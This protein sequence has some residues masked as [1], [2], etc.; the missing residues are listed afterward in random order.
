VSS[1]RKD[2]TQLVREARGAGWN[3]NVTPGGH[4]RFRAPEGG[5]PI[6]AASTPSDPRA[7]AN[8]RAHL[9]RRGLRT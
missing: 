3:V 8:L 5:E 1:F 6:F 7:L 2:L 9:K 4:L